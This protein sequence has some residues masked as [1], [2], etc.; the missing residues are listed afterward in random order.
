MQSVMMSAYYDMQFSRCCISLY[1][2]DMS[3][4][5]DITRN[6][7]KAKEEVSNESYV[8]ES[9]RNLVG[10]LTGDY[11]PKVIHTKTLMKDTKMTHEKSSDKGPMRN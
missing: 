7:H 6:L 3:D 2:S 4:M 9:H 8:D 5:A 1:L 10:Y 11:K